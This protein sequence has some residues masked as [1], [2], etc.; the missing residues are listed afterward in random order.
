MLLW[1][2]AFIVER[3][4]QRSA[5]PL[6]TSSRKA[7][8]ECSNYRRPAAQY[9]REKPTLTKAIVLEGYLPRYAL[10]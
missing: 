10:S 8:G 3:S 1:G 6:S 2:N 5:C 9:V 7:L 4:P